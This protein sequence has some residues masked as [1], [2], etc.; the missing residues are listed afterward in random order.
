MA[1]EFMSVHS[2]EFQNLLKQKKC[3][4]CLH[5]CTY[6]PVDFMGLATKHQ[7]ATCLDRYFCS[8]NDLEI[9]LNDKGKDCFEY[10]LEGLY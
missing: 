8:K 7:S 10:Y 4:I 9:E 5:F 6:T 1:N 3:S 2:K